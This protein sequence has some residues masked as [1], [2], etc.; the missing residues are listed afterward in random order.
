MFSEAYSKTN[1]GFN[2][3]QILDYQKNEKNCLHLLDTYLVCLNSGNI[4][5]LSGIVDTIEE[6]YY[7]SKKQIKSGKTINKLIDI[8]QESKGDISKLDN[9]L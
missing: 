5:Q 3:L 6:G 8:I 4:L 1:N 7:L 9:Y 2:N